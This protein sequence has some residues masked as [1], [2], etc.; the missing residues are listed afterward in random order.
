MRLIYPYINIGYICFFLLK[1]LKIVFFY[2]E[3]YFTSD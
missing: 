2:P 3:K 1:S